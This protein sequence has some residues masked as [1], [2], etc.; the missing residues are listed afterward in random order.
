MRV[1]TPSTTSASPHSS[2]PSGR[3]TL[4]RIAA[5]EHAAAAAIAEHRRLQHGGERGDF[6]RGVLRAA[7]ADDQRILGG[8]QEL[9][10][11]AD[12]GLRRAG[13]S[14]GGS[15]GCGVTA[16]GLPQTSI[17]HCSAAGPGRPDAIDCIASA[18]RRGACSASRISAE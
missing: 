14:A 18:T 9:G 16:P 11:L 1:P 6:G 4:K 8:A 7:A 3:V 17:A 2:R 5:V 10:G 13:R 12:R 15:G